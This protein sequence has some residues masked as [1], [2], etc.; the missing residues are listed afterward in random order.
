LVIFFAC[1]WCFFDGTSSNT[2]PIFGTWEGT[3]PNPYFADTLRNNWA[4]QG[5]P[6]EKLVLH[7]L[8][9]ED[10]FAKMKQS[11]T[12]VDAVVCTLVLCSVHD[13]KQLIQDI[14]D[15]LKP[16]GQFFFLEHVGGKA[17]L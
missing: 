12:G 3:E 7:D 4:A 14:F 11:G 9:A 15:I 6:V 8:T 1:H 10:F 16:G 5:F 13:E 17:T 2:V